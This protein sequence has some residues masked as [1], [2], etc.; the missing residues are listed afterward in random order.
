MSVYL[1]DGGISHRISSDLIEYG[2]I[3][4]TVQRC[5]NHKLAQQ[6]AGKSAFV[7]RYSWDT[8]THVICA[9]AKVSGVPKL[10]QPRDGVLAGTRADPL[11]GR[12]SRMGSRSSGVK[13]GEGATVE[14]AGCCQSEEKVPQHVHCFRTSWY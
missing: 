14:A 2:F 5:I 12:N 1:Q 13:C 9:D 3:F 11:A 8:Y 10:Q 6:R 7:V 4:A